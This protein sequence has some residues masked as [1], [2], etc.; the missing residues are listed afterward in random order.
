M[1]AQPARIERTTRLQ[2]VSHARRDI[3]HLPDGPAQQARDASLAES[4]PL[5][6]NGWIYGYDAD[7][8][9]LL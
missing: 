9:A 1:P 6:G 3:N 8:A 5:V 2:Q 7:E 4:D